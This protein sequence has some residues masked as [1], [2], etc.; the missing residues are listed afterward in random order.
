M[1]VIFLG[2]EGPGWAGSSQFGVNDGPL[3]REQ[4]TDQ[5]ETGPVIATG[6]LPDLLNSVHSFELFNRSDCPDWINATARLR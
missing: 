3:L 2:P 5:R 1:Y 6:P 4:I